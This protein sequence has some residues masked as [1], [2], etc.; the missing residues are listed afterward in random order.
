[1]PQAELA[2]QRLKKSSAPSSYGQVS[3][4]SKAHRREGHL[5]SVQMKL[6]MFTLL[7][8]PSAERSSPAATASRRR[9]GLGTKIKHVRT[10]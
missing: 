5:A 6:V 8:C 3:N 7:Y 4:S 9:T 2:Q 10:C 1:M